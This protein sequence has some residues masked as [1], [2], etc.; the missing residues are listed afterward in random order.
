VVP[1]GNDRALYR[2]LRVAAVSAEARRRTTMTEISSTMEA[3]VTAVDTDGGP[4]ATTD[5]FSLGDVV[6][7][8][9]LTLPDA[10]IAYKTY[11]ELNAARDNTVVM[12]TFFGGQHDDTE[13]MMAAGRALDPA[14]FFIVVPDLL[15]N[16]L[17]SSP[18]NTPPPF[19]GPSFPGVTVH[20][21]VRC[22]HRLVT[23]QLGIDHLRLVIGFSM[24]A[25]AAFHWAA[26]YPDM[27]DALAPICGSAKTSEHNAL[28]LLG[29]RAALT[30]AADFDD[31]RYTTPPVRAL[32]A[33]SRVY[34]SLVLCSEFHRGREYTKLG[35]ASP[36]DT[37]RFFERFFRQRDAN[38]LL[39]SLWTWQHA[40]ISANEL[41][42]G[43]LDAAL[44]A[45]TANTIVMPSTTDFLFQACDSQ[46]EVATMPN[47]E[48]RPIDSTWGHVAGF[49]ANPPDN[50]VVDAA[51]RSLLTESP[52]VP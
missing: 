18:S 16:G 33:F 27:V 38:D 39:A 32:Q 10:R 43:D 15:G 48:L 17:S 24:G 34:A 6:L 4:A 21:N 11:G 19:D 40:D 9:G 52:R 14:K 25:Q 20:D 29:A 8:C 2:L 45:T 35:L 23:E 37:M 30:S 1:Q 49:G 42:N 22:Q 36:D 12:P 26:L 44:N 3:A 47:A 46:A 31:G 5:V 13:L 50:E 51:L 7:Q 28:L 41:Y